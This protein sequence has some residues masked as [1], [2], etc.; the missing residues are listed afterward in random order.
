MGKP[1]AP[2]KMRVGVLFV[3]LWKSSISQTGSNGFPLLFYLLTAK[4]DALVA[5]EHMWNV[6]RG[7]MG[8]G[9]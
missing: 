2:S 4:P 3:G 7:S 6:Q 5:K 1:V 8:M 9:R